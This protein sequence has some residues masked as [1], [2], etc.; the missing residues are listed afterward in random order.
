MMEAIPAAINEV[1]LRRFIEYMIFSKRDEPCV[2][3]SMTVG[4]DDDALGSLVIE[5]ADRLAD[6]R[7]AEGKPLLVVGQVVKV[8]HRKL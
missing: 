3:Q 6:S 4:T 7:P 5:L 1:T 2:G 8:E